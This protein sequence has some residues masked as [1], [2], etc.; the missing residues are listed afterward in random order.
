MLVFGKKHHG[1][2]N[3]GEKKHPCCWHSSLL[4]PK[5]PAADVGFDKLGKALT[6]FDSRGCEGKEL[7]AFVLVKAIRHVDRNLRAETAAKLYALFLINSVETCK[8]LND[9]LRAIGGRTD[10]I[11]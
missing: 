5:C 2:P 4:I 6:A 11:R 9:V 1:S 10:R 3:L 8:Q 7:V